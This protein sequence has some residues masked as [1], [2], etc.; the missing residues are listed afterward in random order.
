MARYPTATGVPTRTQ[1]DLD[2]VDE[3]GGPE[4]ASL[5]AAARAVGDR[6]SLLIADALLGGAAR[7]VDLQDQVVGVSPNVLSRRLK[8][9]Q[10]A[11]I[12]ES[13]A[14]STRP[15]RHDY[16]LT[17]MG[18]DL[19]PALSALSRWGER[20]IAS[21]DGA[22]PE[23]SAPVDLNEPSDPDDDQLQYA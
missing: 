15:R 10:A 3:P 12:I 6:W 9:L 17:A 5:D 1:E 20:L 19:A 18:H 23:P 11:G 7:F 4:E 21:R 8:D 14:Y 22:G 13:R 2:V 16:R